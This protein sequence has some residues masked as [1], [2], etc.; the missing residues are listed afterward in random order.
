[1]NKTDNR[2]IY[3]DI[4]RLVAMLWVVG[5][6]HLIQYTSADYTRY[7]FVGDE[8]VTVLMLSV[9]FFISGW[10]IGRKDFSSKAQ[11]ISFYK[12]RFLRFYILFA[13]AVFVY[14]IFGLNRSVTLLFTTLSATSSYILPQ[15]TTLWFLSMLASFYIL[16]PYVKK[17]FY[18][19]GGILLIIIL[20]NELLTAGVDQRL[21]IYFPVYVSGLYLSDKN[22]VERVINSKVIG[23]LVLFMS[24][25][26]YIG[27]KY[28]VWLIFPFV[29][30]GIL[31][32]L[33]ISR[34]LENFVNERIIAPV[35]YSSLCAYLFHRPIYSGLRH[36][37][38]DVSIYTCLLLYLPICLVVSFYIQHLYDLILGKCKIIRR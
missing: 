27:T 12:T 31:A 22:I 29:F 38:G 34:L 7:S 2:L 6:W 3:I 18:V 13:I 36:I 14:P 15:P 5:W 16:T 4:A 10:M 21:F 35:I 25:V 23:L 30:S 26:L 37:F 11:I 28:F 9:F 8:Y 20:L 32:L 1:M 33:F 17:S 19:G 24:I